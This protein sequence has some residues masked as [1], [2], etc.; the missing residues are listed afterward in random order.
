MKK[1]LKEK[2]VTEIVAFYILGKITLRQMTKRLN[3][4]ANEKLNK[5]E[6]INNRNPIQ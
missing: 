3:S 4:K 6:K 5:S 2:E 1:L